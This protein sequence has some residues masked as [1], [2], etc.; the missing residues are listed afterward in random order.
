MFA[1]A[2][3]RS[4]VVLSP[5]LVVPG[6]R[7]VLVERSVRGCCCVAVSIVEWVG[8]GVSFWFGWVW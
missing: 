2:D 8:R 4:L 7:C 5:L 6:W 3:F 1:G